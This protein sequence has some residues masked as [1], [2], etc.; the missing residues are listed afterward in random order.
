[1]MMMMMM[2]MMMMMMMMMML[3]LTVMVMVK[4]DDEKLEK[5]VVIMRMKVMMVLPGEVFPGAFGVLDERGL[6]CALRS[7]GVGGEHATLT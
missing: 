7:G 2:I 5:T 1:M 4:H 3:M 6:D